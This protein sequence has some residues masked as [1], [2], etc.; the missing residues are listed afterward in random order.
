MTVRQSTGFNSIEDNGASSSHSYR[1]F[2]AL[3]GL[4]RQCYPFYEAISAHA[5]RPST[6]RHVFCFF[7]LTL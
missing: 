4:L 2:P 7:L 6:D 5:I 1:R 3:F